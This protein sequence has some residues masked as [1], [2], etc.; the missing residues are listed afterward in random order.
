M[1]LPESPCQRLKLVLVCMRPSIVV[2][3]PFLDGA[4]QKD[5]TLNLSH[6]NSVFVSPTDWAIIIAYTEMA[7][8]Q[9]HLLHCP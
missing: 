7:W 4:L 2:Y 6:Q 9:L 8:H 3:E 5:M 1:E